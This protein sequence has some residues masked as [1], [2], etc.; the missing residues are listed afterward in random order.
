[1]RAFE[2]SVPQSQEDLATALLWEMG[3]SGIEVRPPRRRRLVLLAY[4]PE[5][6]GLARR[7]RARLS[8]LRGGRVSAVPVPEVDWVARFRDGFRP[9]LAGGF[10]IVPSWMT[11]PADAADP[12]RLVIEPGR[13]FG[14]GTHAT[15]R[16]CIAALEELAAE[17]PLG[18][19]A[20][21][22]TGTGILSIAALRL[23]ARAAAAVEIDPE[24][25]AS[26]RL[27]GRLN[28]AA[29]RLVQGDLARPLRRGAFDTV[30]ANLIASMLTNR[31][32]E[33]HGAGRTGARFV[34]SGILV[35]NLPLVTR[36]WRG[37]GTVT[38]R[39]EGE[40]AALIVRTAGP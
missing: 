13:A 20:D 5:A 3:T 10:R 34:L 1:L 7:L 23:G 11:G 9:F 33:I 39:R 17:R 29:L 37:L 25:I 27:H 24:A 4:F 22:G 14:T 32:P 21:L 30:I 12:R 18:Q 15:T 2:V 19:V 36:R 26:A 31:A 6:P 40:W 8:R 38:V 16:L 28:R 35:E